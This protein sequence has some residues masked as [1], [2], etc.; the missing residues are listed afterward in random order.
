M[1]IA[2]VGAG[3]AGLAS[4]RTLQEFGHDVTVFEK[5][6]D[7]GGVWSATRRYTGLYTQNNKGSYSFSDAPMPKHYPEWPSGEQVQAYLEQYVADHGLGSVLRLSTEVVRAELTDGEDGWLVTARRSGEAVAEP[8]RF[9]H[10]VV[11][12]GIFSDPVIPQFDGLG[13]LLR[14]GGK[15][16]AASQLA[17]VEDARDRHVVVVGYGKSACDVAAEIG[18]VAAG[19]SVVARHLLWKMPKKLGNAVNYKYLLLTR[20]GEAL[21]RYQSV[22]GGMEKFLHGAGDAVRR[23]MLSSV[24]SVATRQLKLKELG[25]VPHTDFE[26]IARSNVSLATDGF[27]AQVESGAIVVHRDSEIER[28]TTDDA[29]APVAVLSDGTTVRADLVV[30]GTGFHQRVPFLDADV[31]GRLL[32]DRG[33]FELYRQILPHDVPHLTFAGYNS[34][35]FSPLSAEVGSIWTAAHLADAVDLPPLEVRREHVRDRL[36]WME[37]RTEGKHARGTNIIPFSMHQIDEML[38]DLDLN[39]SS[40]KRAGQWLLPI[41]PQAYRHVATRLK[42]R[43]SA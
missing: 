6:P 15:I 42:E 14:A 3:F 34:S 24:G 17:T 19:T 39:L 31:T 11:A 43:I 32:D 23:S 22:G 5:A 20:L 7:V 25:L 26:T 36:D 41:D 9:D 30:C 10:V 38:D 35:F 40:G 13:E 8:E 12:N 4:A 21:F 29:G 27:S 1:K 37:K 16:I 33:N 2:V 28:F 18:P